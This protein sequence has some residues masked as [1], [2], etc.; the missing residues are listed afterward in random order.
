MNPSAGSVSIGVVLS[1]GGLRGAAH[2]GVLHRLLEIGMPIDVLV[3]VSAGAIIAAYYA[4]VGLTIETMIGDAPTFKGRHLVA[5]GLA[6]RAPRVVRR[7]LEPLCGVIP[8][9]LRQL[10]SGRF[11]RLHHRVGTLGIVCHDMAADEPRYFTSVHHPGLRVGAIARASAAAPGLFRPSPVVVGGREVQ[12][13]DGGLSDALPVAFTRDWLG[14]T[15][16]VAS[17]CRSRRHEQPGGDHLIYIRP[18][19]DGVEPFRSPASSLLAAVD[20]GRAAVTDPMLDR[21][22]R[23]VGTRSASRPGD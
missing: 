20:A 1:A 16:I 3:G 4:A 22:R 2:L 17:D 8:A 21:V 11:D 9:R 7:L 12:L 10:E 13:A 6:L 14:S 18:E 19:L 23:W 15:H 5:Y